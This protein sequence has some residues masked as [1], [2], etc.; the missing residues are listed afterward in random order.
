M[1]QKVWQTL[2]QENC[3]THI[4]PFA[5]L[6]IGY[7]DYHVERVKMM[8]FGNLFASYYPTMFQ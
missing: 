3:T 6:H 2:I 5:S 4:I 1:A 7:T 8:W